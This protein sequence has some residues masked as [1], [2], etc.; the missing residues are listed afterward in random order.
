MNI[1]EALT[2]ARTLLRGAGVDSP[3]LDAEVL[4]CTVLGCERAGLW[5]NPARLLTPLQAREFFDLVERRRRRV[6]VAYLT[7]RKEFMGLEFSVKPAVLI[8]RPET[9]LLVETALELLKEHPS[10]VVVDVGTGSGAIAVSIAFYHPGAHVI[11][12]DVSTEALSVAAENARRHGLEARITFLAGDLAEALPGDLA[13]RV[14][15]MAA[16]LPYIPTGEMAGLPP[17]VRKE[18]AIALDGGT[19]GLDLY[20]RLVPAAA[21]YLARGGSLLIE[22]GPGQGQKALDL[23]AAPGWE[24]TL[25]L[26]LAGRERIVS[27]GRHS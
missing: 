20:R 14:D 26:D 3:V 22:I 21:F 10:P 16:N 15:L 7:G 13:E 4:L 23:F 24:A 27:A 2:E 19:D 12:T 11:A 18:P 6:P 25:R 5:A 9:E 1:R 17:E 8:P